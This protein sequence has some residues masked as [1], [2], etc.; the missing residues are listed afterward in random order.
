[1]FFF[2]FFNYNYKHLEAKDLNG[3][4]AI[5]SA[6]AFTVAQKGLDRLTVV[7]SYLVLMIYI[8]VVGL[9]EVSGPS[10]SD[11][12]FQHQIFLQQWMDMNHET[13]EPTD[14]Y[15]K[16]KSFQSYNPNTKLFWNRIEKN[17]L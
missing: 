9:I 5:T 14:S 17:Q 1:M 13:D 6:A 12:F 8:L 11:T 10:L 15:L 7:P 2:F 4:G 3:L 16:H